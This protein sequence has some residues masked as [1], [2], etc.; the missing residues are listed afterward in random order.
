MKPYQRQVGPYW[1]EAHLATG[2]MGKVFLASQEVAGAERLVVLKVLDERFRDDEPTKAMFRDEARLLELLHHPNIVVAYGSDV[3]DD[4]PYIALEYLAGDNLSVL[5]RRARHHGR[6]LSLSLIVRVAVQVANALDY[7]HNASDEQGRRL[8]LMHRD[9]SP[10]NIFILYD[11]RVKLLDFGIAWSRRREARTATGMLKGKL[12]YMSPEQVEMKTLDGRSDLF[13]LGVVLWELVAGDKLFDAESDYQIM[14][15]ICELPLPSPRRRRAEIPERV[16]AI[17]MKL[18]QRHPH[19]RFQSAA[20]LRGE[21]MELLLG[22][23]AGSPADEIATCASELLAERRRTKERLIANIRKRGD[24]QTFLFGDLQERDEN[25]ATSDKRLLHRSGDGNTGTGS[26]ADTG[27]GDAQPPEEVQKEARSGNS[28]RW[29]LATAALLGMALLV[30]LVWP[31]GQVAG[32]SPDTLD[33]GLSPDADAADAGLSPHKTAQSQVVIGKIDGSPDAGLSPSAAGLSPQKTQSSRAVAA[34]AGNSV[35][36]GD[37]DAGLAGPAAVLSAADESKPGPVGWLR[38]RTRP[39]VEVYIEGRQ[40]GMTPVDDLE[41]APGVHR[42]R[43][44]NKEAGV[45]TI[46][47]VRIRRNEIT[48]QEYIF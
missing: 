47:K 39:R 10:Q 11:G 8:G 28:L 45:D 1:L 26:A 22:E 29:N 20:E 30:W 44:L 27:G 24:L 12:R 35:L 14:K 25:S 6:P 2:G 9:V 13:S 34:D 16:E 19:Q 48:S 3:L 36:P 17:I 38:L 32:T 40:I 37:G 46:V 33:S 21:L 41:L 23:L 5:A 18:L 7:I 15:Q 43:L 42:L 31:S 4:M